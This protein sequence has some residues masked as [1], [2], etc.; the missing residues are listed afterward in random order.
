VEM[1][2]TNTLLARNLPTVK[3]NEDITIFLLI[4]TNHGIITL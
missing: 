4:I 3:Y 2:K 1:W